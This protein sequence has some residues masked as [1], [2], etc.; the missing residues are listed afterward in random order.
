MNVWHQGRYLAGLILRIGWNP[1]LGYCALI[2]YRGAH[3]DLQPINKLK[4]QS[5]LPVEA[6]FLTPTKPPTLPT[7]SARYTRGMHRCGEVLCAAP[8]RVEPCTERGTGAKLFIALLFRFFSSEKDRGCSDFYFM[9][10]QQPK[11]T[12][13]DMPATYYLQ[14]WRSTTRSSDVIIT[15]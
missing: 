4:L 8:V 6:D 3:R 12:G 14:K 13:L 11:Q 9:W 1:A 15:C 2:F 7:V 10:V 5:T